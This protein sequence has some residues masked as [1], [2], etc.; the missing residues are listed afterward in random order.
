MFYLLAFFAVVTASFFSFC[1]ITFLIVIHEIGHFLMAY[2]LGGKIYKILIYPLG[3]IS[4]F[5]TS[6]NISLFKEFIILLFG[7]LF[8]ILGWL[9]LIHLFP[10]KEVLISTYHYGILFF[11][12]LPIYPLDGGKLLC[13]VFHTIFSYKKA[14]YFT[15]CAG[16]LLLL[17]FFI[18]IVFSFSFNILF[19]SVFLLIKLMKEYQQIP[20]FYEKFLLERYLN[21]YYFKKSK[22]IR[23]SDKFCRGY[24]HLIKEGDFYYL[25]DEYLEKKYKNC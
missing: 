17:C 24:R 10:E 6:Y 20:Y 3:G 19:L 11:N 7:P 16:Y 18:F 21:H 14:F 5:S 4:K 1:V 9:L 13:L 15:F 2:L 25:E 23:D 22:L 12:L 8:Q